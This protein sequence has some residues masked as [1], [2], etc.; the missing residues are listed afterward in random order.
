MF[1][2]P[3]TYGSKMQSFYM[4]FLCYGD[5]IKAV[6]IS[7]GNGDPLIYIKYKLCSYFAD[8]HFKNK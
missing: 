4:K 5:R 6:N 2:I 7:K 8:T 3:V 1:K